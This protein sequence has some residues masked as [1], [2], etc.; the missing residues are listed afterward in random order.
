MH[1]CLSDYFDYMMINPSYYQ[2]LSKVQIYQIEL[3][4][5]KTGIV[6]LS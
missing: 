6:F 1:V 4:E 2:I 5:L 3:V